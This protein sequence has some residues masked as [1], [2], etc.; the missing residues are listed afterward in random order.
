MERVRPAEMGICMAWTA[1]CHQSMAR[2][3]NE[4]QS[5]GIS[6]MAFSVLGGKRGRQEPSSHLSARLISAR[7]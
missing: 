5:L 7:M 3:A 6:P 1:P 4:Q 2:K